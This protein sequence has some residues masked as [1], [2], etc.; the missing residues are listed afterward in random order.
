MKNISKTVWVLSLVSLFTDAASEMLYPILPLYLKTIGF[1]VVLIGVLEGFAEATAGLSK[2]YFG[3]RSDL[4]GKRVPFVQ[5]GYAFSAISKPMMALFIFPIWI[6][7]ARTLDRFGK[8][9]RTGARDAMLSDEATLETKGKIFGLHRAMDTFGAVLGPAFALLYLYFYPD[10]YITLFYI[11]FIPGFFAILATFFLKDNHQDGPKP[12]S[13]TSLFSFLGYWKSSPIGYR[14]VTAGLLAFTLFNSSDVFL[15][16]KAK[17][18]GLDDTMVIGIYIF[19]NLVFALFAFPLGMLAD[20]IGLRKMLISGLVIFAFVYFGMASA[21]NWYVIA[22]LFF[23]YGI[24]GAATEGISKAWISNLTDK[25]DT[26]TAIGNYTGFQS[27]FAMLASSLAGFI[28]YRFGASTT[29]LVTGVATVGVILYFIF[30]MRI[31]T[32]SS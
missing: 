9:I 27:I 14:K 30:G 20:K 32:S 10:D 1:S 4:S 31:K 15:L 26:A 22:G 28:W 17:E 11:A 19:Y 8:G 12:N 3:K 13:K 21:T 7:F 16:L 23:F 6:F 5:I 24:Y 29:F 18:S 25:K 2:G